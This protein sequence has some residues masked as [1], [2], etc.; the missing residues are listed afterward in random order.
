MDHTP[1][2]KYKVKLEE[3]ELG[4][5]KNYT[6]ID[7]PSCSENICAKDINIHDKIAKCDSCD[8][9][10]SID[11]MVQTL[12]VHTGPKDIVL[13]PEGIE[14]FS[15]QDELELSYAQTVN[16]IDYINMILGTVGFLSMIK[17]F[18]GEI[19]YLFPLMCFLIPIC[20]YI[21]RYLIIKNPRTYIRIN[22]LSLTI[23]HK[24]RILSF[25]KVYDVHDID[26]IYVKKSETGTY[27]LYALIN[28]SKG[29]AHQ[30]LVSGIKS[31]S[32]SSYL[33]QEIEKH[34]GIQ[35]RRVPEET[36]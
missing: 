10:F 3:L 35:D 22:R 13:R 6:Q 33:E 18:D 5:P 27:N 15:F 23:E 36:K 11:K 8:A 21:F 25:T 20:Y 28:S 9:V 34:L 12:D 30:K 4:T 16:A 29:Q 2:E 24:P 32:K 7:C 14:T 26:Q 19:S 1:L 17:I 31:F